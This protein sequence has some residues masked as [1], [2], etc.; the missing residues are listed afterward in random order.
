MSNNSKKR[1]NKNDTAIS[2]TPRQINTYSNSQTSN[3]NKRGGIKRPKSDESMSNGE[4]DSKESDVGKFI[5]E[6]GT[7]H[8]EGSQKYYDANGYEYFGKDYNPNNRL[9]DRTFVEET[10]GRFCG[11]N[12]RI[13]DLRK[14]Q[15]GKYD[16]DVT[17]LGFCL[18]VC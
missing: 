9:L 2:E 3:T 11:T 7:N 5:D 6:D 1:K 18:I 17:N 15:L 12:I 4:D 10:I 14:Y 13:Y 16:N 8:E